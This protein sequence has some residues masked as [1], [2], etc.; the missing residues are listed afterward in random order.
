MAIQ[1]DAAEG[2]DEGPDGEDAREGPR[3]GDGKLLDTLIQQFI[4]TV[5]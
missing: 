4:L 2:G 1:L 5:L 3:H